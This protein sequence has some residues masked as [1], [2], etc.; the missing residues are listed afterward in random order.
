[1][2]LS[3]KNIEFEIRVPFKTIENWIAK[4]KHDIDVKVSLKFLAVV[5]SPPR[6][7]LFAL[8]RKGYWADLIG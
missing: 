7:K 4:T 2:G 6:L 5:K 8:P 3:P 1:M